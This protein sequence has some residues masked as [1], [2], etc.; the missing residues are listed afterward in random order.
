MSSHPATTHATA[1]CSLV[2]VR[3]ATGRTHQIRVHLADRHTPI[4]GDDLY[5]IADWNAKLQ[6]QLQQQHEGE[7]VESR[8]LLHAY[9]LGVSHPITGKPMVF[10]AP[11][12]SDFGRIAKA[13]CGPDNLPSF[14]RDDEKQEREA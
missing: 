13:I 9:K 10:K 12:P 11:V 2:Q 1:Q 8:P 3:I 5:G 14:L 7:E 4:Y 6:K